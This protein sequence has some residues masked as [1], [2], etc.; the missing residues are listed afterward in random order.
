M[1]LTCCPPISGLANLLSEENPSQEYLAELWKSDL[2]RGFLW[3]S[4]TQRNVQDV[5]EPCSQGYKLKHASQEYIAPSWSWARYPDPVRW[6]ADITST[7]FGDKV[8]FPEYTLLNAEV[9]AA[10]KSNPYGRVSSAC[11]ELDAKK[12]FGCHSVTMAKQ[13]LCQIWGGT[14]VT[15]LALC[16]LLQVMSSYRQAM[17]T[18]RTFSWIG[19][20][21]SWVVRTI[22]TNL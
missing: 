11:L 10:D 6:I 13:T 21:P 5:L 19:I 4:S 15:G 1:G 12:Y 14:T 20:L 18:L 8:F 16:L 22:Q 3:S 17:S 7:R 9:V 2:H